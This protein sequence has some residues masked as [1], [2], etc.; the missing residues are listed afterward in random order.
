ML[1]ACAD[2][3]E[4]VK[5]RGPTGPQSFTDALEPAAVTDWVADPI[6]RQA[7]F[8]EPVR[9]GAISSLRTPDAPPGVLEGSC[10]PD[11]GGSNPGSFSSNLT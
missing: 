11:P 1:H 7:R 5:D 4:S 6:E 10:L 3:L 9:G 2:R 8:K